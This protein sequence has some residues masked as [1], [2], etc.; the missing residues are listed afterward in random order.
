MK[1][2]APITAK[3]M[4]NNSAPS[5]TSEEVYSAPPLG[6]FIGDRRRDRGS[7]RQQRGAHALS[8]A[9]TKVTAMVS[10][11]ARPRPSIDTAPRCRSESK[12]TTT[13]LNDFPVVR[14]ERI[15]PTL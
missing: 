2:A 15:G 1:R 4:M 8:I 3:V 6:E 13:F 11:S 14:A 12:G 9:I 5:A 10:P 7:R